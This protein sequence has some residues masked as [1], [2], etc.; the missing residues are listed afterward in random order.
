ML[1]FYSHV[2]NVLLLGL[3]QCIEVKNQN[4]DHFM[5]LLSVVFNRRDETRSPQVC[6]CDSHY[7]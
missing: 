2:Q 6:F 7:T 1:C 5:C 4:L 3:L